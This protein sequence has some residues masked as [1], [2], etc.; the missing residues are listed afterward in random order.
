MYIVASIACNILPIIYGLI[1]NFSLDTTLNICSITERPPNPSR[2]AQSKILVDIA[3]TWILDIAY[4]PLVSSIIPD[5]VPDIKLLLPS[6]GDN[7]LV[8]K[9]NKDYSRLIIVDEVSMI[10]TYLMNSLLEGLTNNIK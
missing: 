3:F 5:K 9:Y 6:I 1:D 2:N 7:I 8:N 4:K 10:D